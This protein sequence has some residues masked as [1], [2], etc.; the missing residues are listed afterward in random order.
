MSNKDLLAFVSGKEIVDRDEIIARFGDRY[1]IP[2]YEKLCKSYIAS[3]IAQA[4]A[5]ARDE[6]G[7]R[8]VLAKRGKDGVQY[9]SIDV[10]KNLSVL[11]HIQNR[12]ENDIIGQSASLEKVDSRIEAIESG[13]ILHGGVQNERGQNVCGN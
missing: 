3:K 9:V 10:C 11:I 5:A 12:I 4:L 7:R 1:K 6:D 13:E 2:S 8:L